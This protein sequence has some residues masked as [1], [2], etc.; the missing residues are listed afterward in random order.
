MVD[1]HPLGVAAAFLQTKTHVDVETYL[2]S[3]L[4]Q[5]RLDLE[6]VEEILCENEGKLL[7]HLF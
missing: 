1:V 7:L 6:V 2:S 4:Q 5:S 3:S